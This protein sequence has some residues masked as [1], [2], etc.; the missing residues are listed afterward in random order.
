MLKTI[1]YNITKLKIFLRITTTIKNIIEYT[2]DNSNIKL[3][4]FIKYYGFF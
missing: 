3:V 1:M 2:I 4:V